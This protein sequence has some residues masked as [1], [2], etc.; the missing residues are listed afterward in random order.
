MAL[1][2]IT[3]RA[4]NIA[5]GVTAS[6]P[7][8]L[9]AWQLSSADAGWRWAATALLGLLGAFVLASLLRHR[10]RA[11]A[12]TVL[13]AIPYVTFGLMELIANPGERG[14]ATGCT[15][16]GFIQFVVLAWLL[17]LQRAAG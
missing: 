14:W 9:L 10:P 2:G 8:L 5:I 4:S 7:A 12:W 11:R 16:L 6:L 15:L 13:G 17:R 3:R 1:S